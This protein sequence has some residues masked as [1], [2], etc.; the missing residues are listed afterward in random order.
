VEGALANKSKISLEEAAQRVG[1]ALYGDEWIGRLKKREWW[2][3]ERHG[4]PRAGVSVFFHSD[5]LLQELDLARDRRAWMYKQYNDVHQ[6]F[7]DHG[8]DPGVHEI[9]RDAFECAFEKAFGSADDNPTKVWIT[10]ELQKMK[11]TGELPNDIR[12][13]DLAKI[14]K[15]CMDAAAKAGHVRRSVGWRHI[16]NELPKWDLWPINKIK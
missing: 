15:D 12:I 7:K 6:W 13:T 11:A 9:D 8:F 10:K 2:V 1:H 4:L 5:P 14:L 3:I 16:Q